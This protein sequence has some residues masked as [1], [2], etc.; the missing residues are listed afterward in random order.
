MN[1][2]QSLPTSATVLADTIE[3]NTDLVTPGVLGFLVIFAIALGLYF[4][5]RSMTGK[6]THVRDS[7][8]LLT[9]R[10]DDK[11]GQAV[12]V[13]GAAQRA[14]AEAAGGDAEAGART[15]E[16]TGSAER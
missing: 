9:A 16:E 8:E 15:D 6:L 7:D 5:M 14:S 10:R 13:D 4:L 3:L 2:M 11:A 12:P 1:G